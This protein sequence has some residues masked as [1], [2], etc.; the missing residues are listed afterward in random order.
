MICDCLCEHKGSTYE[1]DSRKCN[2]HGDLKC[3]ECVCNKGW[4]GTACECRTDSFELN[5]PKCNHHGD[6]KCGK[7]ICN[8]GFSG[9]YCECSD[10]NNP[11]ANLNKFVCR[12]DNSSTV[13]CSGRGK[14]ECNKCTCNPRDNN[15]KVTNTK[16]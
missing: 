6:L 9:E 7:C 2:N 15:K 13:D 16:K 10:E 14:C 4:N 5:S 3:G 11:N 12:K 1:H 8:K